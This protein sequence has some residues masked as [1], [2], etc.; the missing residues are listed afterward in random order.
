MKNRWGKQSA[1]AHYLERE[2]KTKGN[3]LIQVV[4]VS[5]NSLTD[6]RRAYP[7]FFLDLGEFRR[8]VKET[9]KRY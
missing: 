3:P 6:L 7:N 5:T 9:V 2:L 4:M 8:V 1:N